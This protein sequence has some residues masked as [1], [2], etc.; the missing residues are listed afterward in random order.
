MR[1]R[2]YFL[3]PGATIG[4][5]APASPSSAAEVDQAIVFLEEMGFRAKTPASLPKA[6]A[7]AT[8]K[9]S[10]YLAGTDDERRFSLHMLMGDPEVKALLAIRGGYGSLRL[11]P[12]LRPLWPLYPPK[13][14]IGYSDLTA[15]HMAR[16]AISDVGGW[17]APMLCDLSAPGH[18]KR[19][20][21]ALL[22]PLTP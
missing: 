18:R 19:L 15:L 2:V 12:A 6:K 4:L 8:E 7:K 22:G 20:K 10:C 1:E 9:A 21:E 5:F 13:P 14:I 11:L 17:H 3:K 16:L